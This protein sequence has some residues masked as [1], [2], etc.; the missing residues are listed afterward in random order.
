MFDLSL[1]VFKETCHQVDI[2][3]IILFIIVIKVVISIIPV[4]K[5][6]HR[7]CHHQHCQA[8]ARSTFDE[9]NSRS[10]TDDEFR[11]M[12]QVFDGDDDYDDD[13]V[14]DDDNVLPA[15]SHQ[16]YSH[17]VGICHNDQRWEYDT[18]T[19][20]PCKNPSSIYR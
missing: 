13:D 8:Y 16:S 14:D 20:P 2:I 3:I 5:C 15:N 12:I 18:V 17:L 9:T 7:D 1:D 19:F 6:H 4:I 10:F 11:D